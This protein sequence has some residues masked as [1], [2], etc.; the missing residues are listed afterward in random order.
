MDH[1]LCRGAFLSIVGASKFLIESVSHEFRETLVRGV[2]IDVYH[3]RPGSGEYKRCDCMGEKAASFISNFAAEFGNPIPEARGQHQSGPTLIRLSMRD[4]RQCLFQRFLASLEGTD[5]V[6]K[7]ISASWFYRIWYQ[8]CSHIV[9]ARRGTDYCDFCS[10]FDRS[11]VHTAADQKVIDE[12]IALYRDERIRYGTQ[13]ARSVQDPQSTRH[14]TI[15]FA[16]DVLL[17]Y[18]GKQPGSIYFKSPYKISIFGICNEAQRRQLNYL[19]HEFSFPVF[20]K[21]GCKNVN[22]VLSLLHDYLGRFPVCPHLLIHADNC[23]GQNKNRWIVF[24]L[25]WRMFAFPHQSIDLDFMVA[26]HT[27]SGADGYFGLIKRKHFRSEAV[28]TITQFAANVVVE[29]SSANTAI[30]VEERPGVIEILTKNTLHAQSVEVASVR[31]YDW[32]RFLESMLKG[33]IK[34]ISRVHRLQFRST[35]TRPR[36]KQ[37]AIHVVEVT[38]C[39]GADS[40]FTPVVKQFALKSVLFD[41]GAFAMVTTVALTGKASKSRSDRRAYL[42]RTILPYVVAGAQKLEEDNR[43]MQQRLLRGSVPQAEII[44]LLSSRGESLIREAREI[45]GLGTVA[46]VPA[47]SFAAALLQV[48]EEDEE[49][50]PTELPA[51]SI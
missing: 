5:N 42:E 40:K 20:G 43:M 17:P 31:F 1:Q 14:I 32:K 22:V 48:M 7:K 46:A 29:S 38:S 33:T 18:F 4:S 19:L 37:R 41:L 39:R 51:E 50:G 10:L 49:V 25:V 27:K 47:T 30:I 6:K 8:R 45:I 12:H 2:R 16:Q 21:G 26:G 9:V 3:R 34:L 36:K 13:I 23:S 15:D 44:S 24:Y 35:L 28:N 11:G